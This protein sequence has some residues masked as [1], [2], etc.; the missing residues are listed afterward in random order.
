VERVFGTFH[1][2]LIIELRLAQARTRTHAQRVF[3]RFRPRYNARFAHAP[4]IPE[5]AWRPVPPDL[6]RIC[7]FKYRRTVAHDNTVQLH[8][9]LLQVQPGPGPDFRFDSDGQPSRKPTIPAPDHPWRRALLAG[10]RRKQL[11][12][13]G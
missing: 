3:D 5:P 12:I 2:R 11:Q 1:D 6:T 4:A 13:Y 7:C 10:A 9:G 8:G